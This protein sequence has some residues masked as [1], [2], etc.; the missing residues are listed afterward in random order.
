MSPRSDLHRGEIWWA[1]LAPPNKTGPVVLV[2]RE[3]AYRVR[4]HLTVAPVTTGI[5]P[6]PTLVPVGTRDGLD[7]DGVVNCDELETIHQ[8]QL[9]ERIA[10]LEPSTLAAVD[11][12]L[13]FSLGLD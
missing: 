6:V 11:D 9:I 13:R 2:S 8:D 4:S 1:T 3:A 5:R 10:T 7:R 12:A